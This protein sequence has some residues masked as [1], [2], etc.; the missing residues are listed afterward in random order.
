MIIAIHQPNYLPYYGYF[1]KIQKSDLFVF[2]DN[3]PYTKNSY[4][5]R[6]RIKTAQRW[7]WLTVP[8][9]SK[10]VLKRAIR[11]VKISN[12]TNWQKKHWKSLKYNYRKAKHF[13]EYKDFFKE[14]YG[15]K[16]V[17]LAD[18]NEYLIKK[19]CSFLEIE[20]NFLDASE[21]DVSGSKTDL[22]I[23][24]CETV[25]ADTYLSG[26]GGKGYL[27][28]EKFRLCDINLRYQEPK[29]PKYTQLFGDFTPY[30]SIVDMLFCEGR[31]L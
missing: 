17:Y 11:K 5:N 28:E 23:N 1:H 3:V 31:L 26:Q 4:I 13:D 6:N 30:L 21:L 12:V 20:C 16:W 10:D 29:Q 2:L 25:G 14:V 9:E 24:I 19:V 27:E 15:K 18:L 7:S 8:I 22:L